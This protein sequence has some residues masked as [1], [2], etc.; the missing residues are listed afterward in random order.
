MEK[1][2]RKAE[3]ETGKNAVID[4][5]IVCCI[6]CRLGFPGI[7][8]EYSGI[9]TPLFDYG[10]SLLQ[11]ILIMITSGDT[12]GEIRLLDWKKKYTMV[13][14]ML[15]LLTFQ[16]LL[17][18]ASKISEL[19][20]CIRFGIT[21]IFG[22]W[23]ADYYEVKRLLKIISSALTIFAGMNLLLFFV[24]RGIGFYYDEEGV[25]LFR[26]L[27]T[28]KNPLGEELAFGIVLQ[29][30]LFF[31]QWRDKEK[32]GKIQII[33]F[34]SQIFLLL[35]TKATGALFTALIPIL[36]LFFR[37]RKTFGLPRVH[38]GYFYIIVSVG[39]LFVALTILPLFSPLLEAMGK[40][41]T[42]SNRTYIWEQ[43]IPFML[44]SHTF[45]GYG[46]LMFWYDENALQN[47]QNRF[48]RDSWFREMAYGSHNTL[49][50][51]WLD[52][53]LIG[54]A[55]YFLVLLYSFRKFRHFTEEQY[56]ACS[57][58]MLPLLIRGLT[59]RS[60][61][62]ANYLTLFLFI[63]LGIACTSGEIIPPLYPRRPFLKQETE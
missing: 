16:S 19:T 37:E 1:A 46:M 40:D 23:L 60:F 3:Y 38:W 12:V 32:I 8:S 28:R 36:Y 63:V 25:Y 61:S 2:V 27:Q 56:L 58:F 13:Y 39:F 57:A 26:G 55:V 29:A 33:S 20:T 15:M 48:A 45:T 7:L 42:L 54:I 5:L 51:M 41:A 34:A 22:L 50:E 18:A 53:G 11:I 4:F 49:L 30:A 52:I 35:E 6:V 31:M 62:N 10:S 21:A 47:L 44:G 43:V 24:F 17:V 9:L 59:E 14:L